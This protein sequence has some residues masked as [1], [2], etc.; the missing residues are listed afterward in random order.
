MSTPMLEVKSIHAQLLSLI[1][2]LRSNMGWMN[3]MQWMHSI[4]NMC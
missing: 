1:S 2:I 4:V 3:E